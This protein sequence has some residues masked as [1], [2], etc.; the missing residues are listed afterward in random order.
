MQLEARLGSLWQTTTYRIAYDR[1][2]TGDVC[3]RCLIRA[4]HPDSGDSVST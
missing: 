4:Y 1:E 3:K 2:M